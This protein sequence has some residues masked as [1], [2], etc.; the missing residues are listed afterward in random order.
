[1]Y[2]GET[3][4]QFGVRLAEH[5]KEEEKTGNRN[6][7]RSSSRSSAIEYHK[8]A[9]TD[10]VCQHR[11]TGNFLPGGGAV[12]HLPKKLSQVAQIFTK[13]SKRNEGHTMH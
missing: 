8:S 9:I 6:F 2:I 4:R 1:M 13:Q 5:R 11:R 12:N 3:G 7:T 10:H